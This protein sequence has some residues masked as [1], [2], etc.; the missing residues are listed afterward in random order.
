[1]VAGE[2]QWLEVEVFVFAFCIWELEESKA[3]CGWGLGQCIPEDASRSALKRGRNRFTAPGL[4]PPL[5][6]HSALK[7]E[8]PRQWACVPEAPGCHGHPAAPASPAWRPLLTMSLQPFQGLA[9]A[10]RVLEGQGLSRASAPNPCQDLRFFS[11]L[12][13]S[14]AIPYLS[15]CHRPFLSYIPV[16]SLDFELLKLRIW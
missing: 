6:R 16:S 2:G 4:R 7:V 12:P 10:R 3:E 13:L 8:C 15:S 11:L 14:P 1:M 5:G 9:P